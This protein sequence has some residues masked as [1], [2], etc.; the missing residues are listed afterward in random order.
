[1]ACGGSPV[2]LENVVGSDAGDVS[3]GDAGSVSD[4]G[5]T[6][7]AYV[8][9]PDDAS[10]EADGRACFVYPLATGA[11]GT[12]CEPIGTG[13]PNPGCGDSCSP[14]NVGYTCTDGPPPL[15]GVRSGG[16]AYS[17][18]SD[19]TAC[20]RDRGRDSLCMGAGYVDAGRLYAWACAAK[21][22]DPN[23]GIAAPPHD[24][25]QGAGEA[26]GLIFDCCPFETP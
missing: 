26:P 12:N 7:D 5:S 4:A 14:V 25:C 15:D 9:P 6:L 23:N 22:D 3:S 10:T 18:C 24:T 8:P 2:I 17:Y 11:S 13:Q 16:V 21:P 20:V 1:M 19:Q